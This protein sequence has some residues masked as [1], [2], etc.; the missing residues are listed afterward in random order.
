MTLT[1]D[2]HQVMTFDE[3]RLQLLERLRVCRD[4]ASARNIIAEGEL[5]LV[6][7]QLTQLTH[8][9]FWESMEEQLDALGEEAKF[10]AD[11]KAADTLGIVVAAAR[12]RIARYRARLTDGLSEGADL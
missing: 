7:G 8:D 4:P 1:K 6:N 5:M 3:Y 2:D 11:P 9:R 12:S 10:L